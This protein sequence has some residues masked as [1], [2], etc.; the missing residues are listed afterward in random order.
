MISAF[1]NFACVL[2]PEL[3]K[4]GLSESLKSSNQLVRSPEFCT[5][6]ASP[7][8]GKQQERHS[9]SRPHIHTCPHSFH[10]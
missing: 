1:L 7:R 4:S 10:A 6:R 8:L 5:H 9:E 2:Q 3:K